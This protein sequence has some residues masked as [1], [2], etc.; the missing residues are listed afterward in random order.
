MTAYLDKM[1]GSI[2]SLEE[3]KALDLDTYPKDVGLE[4]IY[5]G[6]GKVG[7]ACECRLCGAPLGSRDPDTAA[8]I[9][10]GICRDCDCC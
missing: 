4:P 5:K 3:W 8:W 6:P 10:L 7:I 1:T 9:R 2:L